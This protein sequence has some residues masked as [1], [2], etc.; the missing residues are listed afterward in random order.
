[1]SRH[2]SRQR[3]RWASAVGAS[4][5]IV[6]LAVAAY[7]VAQGD[8][9]GRIS[10]VATE[11][12]GD[13]AQSEPRQTGA[14]WISE[15]AISQS[16][17]SLEEEMAE[18]AAE[19]EVQETEGLVPVE[20]PAGDTTLSYIE[21]LAPSLEALGVAGEPLS[22]VDEVRGNGELNSRL[23]AWESEDGSSIQLIVNYLERPLPL[24]AV[25]VPEAVS[26]ESLNDGSELLSTST[27]SFTQSLRV[28]PSGV[29][30]NVVVVGA[31]FSNEDSA[32]DDAVRDVVAGL[33]AP[34]S[35]SL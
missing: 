31:G 12:S 30:V 4:L 14:D 28:F 29:V 11:G 15:E 20:Q 26:R 32:L 7:L 23:V 9:A 17:N 5:L 33:P 8:D 27:R 22:A 16:D 35:Q 10:Q 13:E 19:A 21:E 2:A 34:P 18:I 3:P 1:M 24:D 25:G 6:I